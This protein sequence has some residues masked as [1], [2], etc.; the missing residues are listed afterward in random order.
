MAPE[1]VRCGNMLGINVGESV[2]AAGVWASHTQYG[3]QFKVEE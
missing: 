3:R 1:T 2:I